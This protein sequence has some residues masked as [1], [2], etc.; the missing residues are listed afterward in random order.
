MRLEKVLPEIMHS[1]Q[2]R[3]LKEDPS[4]LQLEQLMM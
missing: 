3:L 1:N 2:M 4:L